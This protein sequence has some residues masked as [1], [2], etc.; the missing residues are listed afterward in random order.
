ML[1]KP[2]ESETDDVE[3]ATVRCSIDMIN[4]VDLNC[5][6]QYLPR[7]LKFP[8]LIMLNRMRCWAWTSWVNTQWCHSRDRSKVPLGQWSGPCHGSQGLGAHGLA[9][10]INETL[11]GK[12]R[13]GT[14]TQSAGF[15]KCGSTSPQRTSLVVQQL[16][17]WA[18]NAG[19]LG[20]IPG[21]GTRSHV[22]Q[23]RPS[24]AK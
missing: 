1:P 19:G 6:T 17:L 18:P 10:T 22:L 8:F 2:E 23:L 21:Q 3:E 15:I 13:A 11:H 24:V 4:F 9:G 5:L 7:L 16:R 12:N 14:V 20:S